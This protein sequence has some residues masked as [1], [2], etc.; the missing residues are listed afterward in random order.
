MSV[1]YF[2]REKS[3]KNNPLSRKSGWI[4]PQPQN[5]NLLNYYSL[6]LNELNDFCKTINPKRFPKN[7]TSDEKKVLTELSQIKI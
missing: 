6:T 2:S 3:C 4:A 7:I 1:K 5:F